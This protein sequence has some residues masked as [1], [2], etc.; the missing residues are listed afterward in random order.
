[1]KFPFLLAAL[2]LAACS[3]PPAGP[4]PI[5]SSWYRPMDSETHEF[6]D[7]PNYLYQP[8]QQSRLTEAI[9]ALGEKPLLQLSTSEA[10]RYAGNDLR[11]PME[12]RPFLIHAL[13][14]PQ[15]KVHVYFADRALWVDALGG[16]PDNSAIKEHPLVIFIDE[17][18]PDVYVSAGQSSSFQST[19]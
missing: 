13:S 11:M 2:W 5:S 8:V 14:R 4:D 15:G 17:V 19:E 9:A 16:E 7:Y 6:I 12:L 1:M 10:E 18:P 3:P